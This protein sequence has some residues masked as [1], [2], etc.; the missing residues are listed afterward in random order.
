MNKFDE[1]DLVYLKKSEPLI[2]RQYMLEDRIAVVTD[3]G[4]PNVLHLCFKFGGTNAFTLTW[5]P[6]ISCEKIK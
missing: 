4:I 6:M 5:V 3:A 2:P 1:G